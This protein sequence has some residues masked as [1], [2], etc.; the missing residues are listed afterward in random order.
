MDATEKAARRRGYNGFSLDDIAGEVGIKKS[1]I[2][3][4]FSSKS[5]LIAAIFKRFS[6]QIFAFLDRITREEKR[7][8]E[9]LIAYIDVTK[10]LLEEGQSICLSI[11]LNADRKSLLAEIVDDLALF[12]QV[13]IDWLTKAFELG[14]SDGSINDVGDPVEEANAC[15]ALVDGAQLMARAHQNPALYDQATALLRSRIIL[16]SDQDVAR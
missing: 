15:L 5:A 3:Y 6:A 7:A 8:G 14:L 2:Y 13:N 9:R 10:S 16:A 1:S 11:A 12:H 4:H